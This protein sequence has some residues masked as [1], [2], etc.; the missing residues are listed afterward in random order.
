MTRA[1]TRPR[2][3]RA[4]TSTPLGPS[5]VHARLRE[6]EETLRAIR[7]GEVDALVVQDESPDAQVFTLSSADRPYRMFVENMRDGAAT[8]SAS[9]VVLYANLSL[10]GLLARPLGQV[11][12]SPIT[13]L[14]AEADHEALLGISGRAGG[15]IEVDLVSAGGHRVPVRINSSTLDVGEHVLLCLTF[16]DLTEQ[17]AHKLEIDRLQQERVREL[18][19]AQDVL[20]QQA[21]HDA[22]TGLANRT[23]L[24]DRT[25]Q[26]LA[27]AER[28]DPSVGLIFI[29]LDDFKQIND[30][31]GHAA[32]DA[33]L[34]Q[35]AARILGV[36][37]PM[38]SVARLGGDEFVV[39]LPGLSGSQDA[40]LIADRIASQMAAPIKLDPGSVS[41]TASMGIAI[42]DPWLVGSEHTSG[43]LIKQADMAMYDAKSLGG[44][45]SQLFESLSAASDSKAHQKTQRSRAARFGS[46]NRP[47]PAAEVA[48]CAG[49]L[50]TVSNYHLASQL[51]QASDTLFHSA[52]DHSPSGVSVIGLDGRWQ[53]INDTC[54]RLLGYARTDLIGA[55]FTDFT[56]P[57]DVADDQEFMAAAIA[58]GRV[59]SDREKRYLRKDGS[60]V[61][62]RVQT[63]LVRDE[64]GEPLCFVSHVQDMTERRAAQDLL[65][66]SE[67]TLRSVIDNSPAIICVKGR[68][69][70]Y[71]LVNKEFERVFGVTSD[72]IVG[73]SDAELH[74][75]SS[76]KSI[77]ANDLAVLDGGQAALDEEVIEV[78]GEEHVFLRNRFALLDEHGEINAVCTS[79]TDITERRLEEHTKR[80][81]LQC[82]ELIYSALAQNRFVLYGQPIVDLATMRHCRVE[83]LI[84]MKK[85]RDGEELVAP[86]GFLPAAERFDLVGVIDEWVINRAVEF[87]TAGRH[88]TVNVSA[89]TISSSADVDRIEQAVIASGAAKNLVFEITETAV[90]DNLDEAR[91]FVT[92]LRKLGCAVALD[93]FGVG[94]GTFTY[95]RHLPVDYLKIDMQFV[96]DLLSDDDGRR[97]VQAIVGIALQY[98]IETIAEGVEDQ[99]TMEELHRIGVDYAQGYWIGR[100]APL[101]ANW[102]QPRHRRREDTPLT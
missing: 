26:A 24:V 18:E 22:L 101:P 12:G 57:D 84:R 95:L 13:C 68:D 42:A 40:I 80:E 67:R 10:A 88:V 14:I 4:A 11:I 79:S 21:T 38:D 3:G 71:K 100:P 97:V 35:V 53:R 61:W 37:R 46:E 20:T 102:S 50:A 59:G 66:E 94:H 16:A 90:S 70:R 56:H 55:V 92:R 52:F 28:S 63:E 29:D 5:D 72:W 82:S 1:E 48:S 93:D 36:V 45:R 17:N 31:Y 87:A 65:R 23:L 8:V 2:P 44:S 39:L 99:A 54:C 47:A 85:E 49:S 75:A 69:H 86:G 6:A 25:T 19:R 78:D 51:D 73:R 58:G 62:A 43:R 98:K 74:S 34:C 9:G 96:R 76:L 33:V 7:S 32:G 60:L 91:T 89:K 15:T 83:L 41:V 30:T 27:F 81:R 77:R 64:R